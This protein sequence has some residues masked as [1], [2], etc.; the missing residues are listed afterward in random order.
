MSIVTKSSDSSIPTRQHNAHTPA[1][2]PTEHAPEQAQ[3]AH[4]TPSFAWASRVEANFRASVEGM[5][6]AYYMLDCVRDD[7]GEILDF[8]FVYVNRRGEEQ[9]GMPREALIGQRLCEM[10]PVN[11]AGGFFDKYRRVVET[12]KT[13]DEEFT[14]ERGGEQWFHHQVVSIGD[15]IAI[16]E[17]NISERK[18][19]ER[20]L[21]DHQTQEAVLQKQ[22]ELT[23]L[24]SEMMLR[25]A[26][27]FRTPL[28]SIG[29]AGD[30]LDRY[31]D[32]LTHEQVSAQ[33]EQIKTQIAHIEQML[34]AIA[35]AVS[36]LDEADYVTSL[37][38]IDLYAF[39]CDVIA[40]ACALYQVNSRFN[41]AQQSAP[42]L[43]RLNPRLLNLILSNLLS[44]AVKFSSSES[45]I[46]V[47]VCRAS[48]QG[49][50]SIHDGGIGILPEDLPHIF[51]P[52]FRGHNFDEVP[53]MGVGLTIVKNAVELLDGEIIVTSTP[54]RGTSV[55]VL[56][57]LAVAASS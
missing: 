24:K 33:V 39:T 5:L 46:R 52:F 29:L 31:L 10:L 20:A 11:L 57:P 49:S 45:V 3:S 7:E 16:S 40:H 42:V 26:H 25:I 23:R 50:I 51:E 34:N 9:L 43:V 54:D 30:I 27:E 55:R 6:D 41:V 47:E 44:N 32:R 37:V 17:R 14:L 1:H 15:G 56:L 53:G 13:L 28:T 2:S 18:L 4:P 19:L 38:E 48:G 21:R 35:F 22:L 12:G 36:G 8:E